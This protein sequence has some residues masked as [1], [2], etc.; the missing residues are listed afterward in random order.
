MT[1]PDGS[2]DVSFVPVWPAGAANWIQTTPGQG[3]FADFRCSGAS[4]AD[5]SQAWQLNHIKAFQP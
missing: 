5:F 3:W 2:V 1:N 4:E